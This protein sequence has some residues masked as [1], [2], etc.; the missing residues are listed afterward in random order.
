MKKILECLLTFVIVFAVIFIIK[1]F[2]D[3][4]NLYT[5]NKNVENDKKI[6]LKE[7]KELYF[8]SKN[9]ELTLYTTSGYYFMYQEGNTNS[10]TFEI[11]DNNIIFTQTKLYNDTCYN[12]S[13]YT[14]SKPI[15]I[16]DNKIYSI[17][18]NDDKL[19]TTN[20]ESLV[21]TK[22]ILLYNDF[23]CSKIEKKVVTNKSS[24][25]KSKNNT[26]NNSVKDNNISTDEPLTWNIVS[27]YD[28]C[29]QTIT[30]VYEDDEYDYYVPNPCIANLSYIEYSNGEKYTIIEALN[31]RKLTP[32][33]LIEK[34]V[35]IYKNPKN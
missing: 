31:K 19:Y 34:G 28:S 25:N 5:K 21:N 16:I 6:E 35:N 2:I 32:N 23:E 15:E 10:G 22:K 12:L 24:S 29:A 11:L 18:I 1:L 26:S 7:N 8:T 3:D 9:I 17:T 13:T 30:K 14:Y 27:N 20:K 33:E 4:D